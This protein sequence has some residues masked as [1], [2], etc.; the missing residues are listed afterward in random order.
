METGIYSH[1]HRSSEGGSEEEEGPERAEAELYHEPG[2]DVEL[3]HGV[4]EVHHQ[5]H[6]AHP[7]P[8]HRHEHEPLAH[9]LL[10]VVG[11]GDHHTHK[12]QQVRQLIRQRLKKILFTTL[13]TYNHNRLDR[14]GQ[15]LDVTW[16]PSEVD[17]NMRL[18][19]GC[20]SLELHAGGWWYLFFLYYN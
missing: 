3:L 4:D 7:E 6:R 8:G 2:D 10:L 17:L 15:S 18:R 5:Q 20:V 19:D 9:R 1:L 13:H 16:V 12:P 14:T 11:R